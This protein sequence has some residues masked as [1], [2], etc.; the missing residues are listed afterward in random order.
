MIILNFIIL[1]EDTQIEI[2][3]IRRKYPNATDYWDINWVDCTVSVNIPGYKAHFSADLTTN[4]IRDFYTE[5]I[6]METD[7]KGQAKLNNPKDKQSG[8]YISMSLK[9][10]A[11]KGYK[12][13]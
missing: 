1:G 7:L 13:M 8:A 4:E 3:V 9:E 10:L 5:L 12:L 11:N 2:E 6:R